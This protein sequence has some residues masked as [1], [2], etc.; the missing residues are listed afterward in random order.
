M[1]SSVIEQRRSCPSHEDLL[2]WVNFFF[3]TSCGAPDGGSGEAATAVA[4]NRESPVYLGIFLINSPLFCAHDVHLL[5]IYLMLSQ[6]MCPTP[7]SKGQVM[8]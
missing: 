4:A 7:Y 6:Q 5:S 1:L 8:C 3:K 2:N